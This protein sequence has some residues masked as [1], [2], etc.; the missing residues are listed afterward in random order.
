M[1]VIGWKTL[2]H[3]V[4][5]LRS[6]FTQG[7]LILGYHHI[8]E[9]PWNP[10]SIRV[11]PRHFKE[12]L[13][14]LS[15]L[16]HPIGL[17]ELT[18]CLKNGSLPSRAVV[19]T[20]DDG[21]ANLLHEV[22]PLLERYEIP[23]TVFVTTGYMGRE[24]WWDELERLIFLP[25]NLPKRLSLVVDGADF[26][27]QL[28]EKASEH[29]EEERL[30]A[31]KHLLLGLYKRLLFLDADKRE[32]LVAHIRAWAGQEHSTNNSNKV[33]SAN[34]IIELAS[35][36][37]IE[38]GTHTRTH[39]ILAELPEENQLSEI[40]ESRA[41]LEGLLSDP[42]LSLSY[43]NGSF[44][45]YTRRIVQQEGFIC[46]CAS[47]NDVACRP[48]QIFELPRFW[49]PDWDGRAFSRWLKR[50]LNRGRNAI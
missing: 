37:M 16:A 14:T 29:S 23:A 40:Q 38:V 42:V 21:Y 47:H 30:L 33:L 49:V 48:S 35:S 31:R 1:K 20:F 50:W 9:T 25:Q 39:P 28:S 2:Q 12:H 4:L 24:L 22:K 27:W 32:K 5:W 13:E 44:S 11:R 45:E 41:S 26:Q 19:L 34:E 10:Y 15:K 36:G 43:P 6:R 8:S 7:A 17:Q 3:S 46:A 18:Q